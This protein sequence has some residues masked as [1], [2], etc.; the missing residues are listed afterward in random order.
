M[1]F[2]QDGKIY[3]FSDKRIRDL[4]ESYAARGVPNYS[5]AYATWISPLDYLSLTC[6]DVDAFL[7]KAKPLDYKALCDERQEIYLT[8]DFED[9][10]VVGHEGRHRMAALHKAGAELV[11]IAVHAYGENGRYEREFIDEVTV[12]GQ[13]FFYLEKPC[14]AKGVV[15]LRGLTPLSQAY[16]QQV[17]AVF[18]PFPALGTFIG[19]KVYADK[20]Y[21]GCIKGFS[22][23]AEY[24]KEM[25]TNN[26][27]KVAYVHIHDDIH[28]KG[29]C[30]SIINLFD[31]LNWTSEGRFCVLSAPALDDLI[32]SSKQEANASR[33]DRD[34]KFK[35]D[36]V[37][38]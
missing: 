23:C 34:I 17:R 38:R 2:S 27:F 33:E 11:A 12:S 1:V 13:D 31:F 32:Q 14:K 5:Q 20:A 19:K 10:E 24:V 28:S 30:N 7:E 6:S 8:V 16:K 35:S 21:L 15:K 9:G 29:C 22:D 36:I 4:Y 3:N 18:G 37:T 25:H 26:P